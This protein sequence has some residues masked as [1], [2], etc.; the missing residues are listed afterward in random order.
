V[1]HRLAIM[2]KDG[3]WIL[4]E[5]EEATQHVLRVLADRGARYRFGAPLDVRW[6]AG[7]WS[8]HFEFPH[9]S[10]RVRT[11]FV[12]RP[13]RISPGVLK[14]LWRGQ[15][16]HEPPFVGL[17]E[18]A[19]IK[20]TDREKDYAVIGDLARMMPDIEEQFL[21]SRSA[22]DLIELARANPKLATNLATRRSVLKQVANGRVRLEAALDAE[23]RALMHA[24]ERRLARY[25]RAAKQWYSLWPELDREIRG[26]PLLEAHRILVNRAKGNLAPRPRP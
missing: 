11:D 10:L 25:E 24:N 12:S 23:R 16:N 26:R 8:S 2:S 22:R 13:P 1:L 19:E 21:Q 7:G 4:R 14:R 6:L 9:G 17:G 3:D 15:E 5:D 20:K 18:L